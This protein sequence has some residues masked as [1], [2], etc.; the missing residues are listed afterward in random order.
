MTQLA[1]APALDA[2]GSLKLRPAGHTQSNDFNYELIY[3]WPKALKL[4]KEKSILLLI[5]DK[6]KGG[7]KATI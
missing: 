6:A 2:I 5:F 3:L 7:L 1:S 4:L